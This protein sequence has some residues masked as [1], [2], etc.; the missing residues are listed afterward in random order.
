MTD[1]GPKKPG[2]LDPWRK[3]EPLRQA[4]P[5]PQPPSDKIDI[6]DV[7]KDADL[8]I[9]G[10]YV[11]RSRHACFDV[12][13]HRVVKP[14]DAVGVLAGL[15]DRGWARWRQSR[16]RSRVP[17]IGVR[18]EDYAW[19]VPADDD[20]DGQPASQLAGGAARLWFSEKPLAEG[21]LVLA[22]IL[23]EPAA[24]HVLHKHGVT[25]MIAV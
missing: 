20:E 9:P 19:N 1:D 7:D 22:R 4:P 17:S 5:R 6:Q 16:G 2:I 18:H 3:V 23:R 10:R 14:G 8:R 24:A 21:M 11:I 15:P 12:T 13:S 25:V